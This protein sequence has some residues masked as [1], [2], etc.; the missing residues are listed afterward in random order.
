MITKPVLFHLMPNFAPKIVY[1]IFLVTF[2]KKLRNNFFVCWVL[3]SVFSKLIVSLTPKNQSTN[4]YVFFLI[5]RR[6]PLLLRLK[7]QDVYL[8]LETVEEV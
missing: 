7:N 3:A 4:F 5:E 2:I 1:I 8:I 6:K